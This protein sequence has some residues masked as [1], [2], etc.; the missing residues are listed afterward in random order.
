MSNSVRPH[1]RQPI[2]LLRPWDFPGKSLP[3]KTAS[4]FGARITSDLLIQHVG[5]FLAHHM[6]LIMISQVN[7]LTLEQSCMALS[8]KKNYCTQYYV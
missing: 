8:Q 4:S 2:T 7:E 3:Y 1:R 5:Q 6:C